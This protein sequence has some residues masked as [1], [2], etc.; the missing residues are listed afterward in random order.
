M[1]DQCEEFKKSE[2]DGGSIRGFC[3]GIYYHEREKF[4][5][6]YRAVI[7]AAK[8]EAQRAAIQAAEEAKAT[9]KAQAEQE[10]ILAAERAKI[11][12]EERAKAQAAAEEQRKVEAAARFKAQQEAEEQR[13]IAAEYTPL[14][15]VLAKTPAPVGKDSQPEEKQPESPLMVTITA[16]EYDHLTRDSLLLDCL[17]G[18]GVDNWE[19][20]DFAIDQFNEMLRPKM[21]TGYTETETLLLD[22]I[23]ELEA[24]VKLLRKEL[25]FMGCRRI[26]TNSQTEVKPT[27]GE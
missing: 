8:L 14:P 4:E 10:A 19:G 17:R 15:P 23:K 25:W 3:I 22:R 1:T 20:W 2:F 24:Q 9:A 27:K 5:L 16:D 18:A 7:E 13:K 12:A 26:Y 11:Q 6:A 21:T